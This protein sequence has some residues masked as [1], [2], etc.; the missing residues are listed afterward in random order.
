MVTSGVLER[1]SRGVYQTSE[2]NDGTGENSFRMATLRCGI[3]SAICLMSALE[4]YHVTDEI[5]NRVWIFVPE[6]KRVLSKE[7]KL[8]RSRKPQWNI[9]IHKTKSYWITT[10][11]R[12]LVD[13]LLHKKTIGFQ[14][15]IG[16]IKQSVAQKKV[17]LGAVYDMAIKMGV[18]HRIISYV[19]ALAS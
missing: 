14:I 11:E 8:I 7:L 19:E 18:G 13:C 1:L 12:T 17:K 2:M 5:T 15:A 10:L 6:S 9:G 4:H 16:A 3:P